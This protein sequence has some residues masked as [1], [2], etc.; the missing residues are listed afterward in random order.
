MTSETTTGRGERDHF[1][2]GLASPINLTALQAVI[3]AVQTI[4]PEGSLGVPQQGESAALLIPKRA[5][6][7]GSRIIPQD[8][9]TAIREGTQVEAD[10]LAS[11]AD[12]TIMAPGAVEMTPP[13][14]TLNLL[15]GYC[16]AL[17]NSLPEGSNAIQQTI[18]L[19]DR[20]EPYVLS[21]QPKAQA[22]KHAPVE[23]KEGS[24]WVGQ[25]SADSSPSEGDR[26]RRKVLQRLSSMSNVNRVLNKAT[27][28]QITEALK[29]D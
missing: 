10:D 2:I 14:E 11:Q 17:L 26:L 1:R 23:W 19:P 28:A 15:S 16:H 20:P 8:V 6:L 4:W 29:T 24:G 13:P 12:I 27:K 9:V 25:G 22:E 7:D 5:L 3:S 21:I 18:H